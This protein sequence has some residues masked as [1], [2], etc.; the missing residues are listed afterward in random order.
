MGSAAMKELNETEVIEINED[1]MEEKPRKLTKKE[2]RVCYQ[3]SVWQNSVT[4]LYWLMLTPSQI[5]L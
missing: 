4:W 1:D 5:E 3:M 2:K